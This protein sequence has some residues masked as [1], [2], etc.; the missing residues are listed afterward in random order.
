MK[1]KLRPSKIYPNLMPLLA[2]ISETSYK[3]YK[4]TQPEN[5]GK[6]LDIKKQSVQQHIDKRKEKKA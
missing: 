6:A 2:E 3:L 1:Q 5:I 4:L